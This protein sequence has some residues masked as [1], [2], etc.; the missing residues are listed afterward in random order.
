M[1]ATLRQRIFSRLW[2]GRLFSVTSD[3]ALNIGLPIYI[4]LQ[5]LPAI[6]ALSR[7]S[8]RKRSDDTNTHSPGTC[9][10]AG[11]GKADRPYAPPWTRMLT[12]CAQEYR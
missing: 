4:Y 5:G 8:A 10:D 7:Q 9:P 3:W 6:A 2:L 11:G 12:A 1:I